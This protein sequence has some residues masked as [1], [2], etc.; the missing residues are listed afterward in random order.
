[1]N[2]DIF[3]IMHNRINGDDL[4]KYVGM[5]LAIFIILV[6]G[7]MAGDPNG[8]EP[9]T[10]IGLLMLFLGIIWLIV[11]AVRANRSRPDRA[12]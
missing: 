9:N 2:C 1:M 5:G 3:G 6:G 7:W 10:T 4:M 8:Q 12:G 11:G